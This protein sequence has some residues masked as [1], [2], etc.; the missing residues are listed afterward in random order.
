MPEQLG[1]KYLTRIPGV[2]SGRTIVENTR[3]GVHDVVA[4]V[5]PRASIDEAI[6]AFPVL[7]RGPVYECMAYYED[8]RDEIDLIIAENRA[9][10]LS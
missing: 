9:P 7:T 8:H 2:R 4:I 10:R 5:Q 3:I 6:E 1:Y